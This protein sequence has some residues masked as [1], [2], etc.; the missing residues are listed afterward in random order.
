MLLPE[1]K[2][3][4]K[5]LNS[6]KAQNRQTTSMKQQQNRR[7]AKNEKFHTPKEPGM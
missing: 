5:E 1:Q 4:R 2:E 6:K 3:N 7:A